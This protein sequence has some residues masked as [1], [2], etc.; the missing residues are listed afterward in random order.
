[1]G[2]ALLRDRGQRGVAPIDDHPGETAA[3]FQDKKP[4]AGVLTGSGKGRVA[5]D[6]GDNRSIAAP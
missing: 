1:V 5:M 2:F 4:V 6:Q 3:E